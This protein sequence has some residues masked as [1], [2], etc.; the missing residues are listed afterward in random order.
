[1]LFHKHGGTS[2]AVVNCMSHISIF[3]PTKAT[4]KMANGKTGHAEGIGIILCYFHNCPIIFLVGPVCC[5]P[6]HPSN[7]TSRVTSNFML[8]L[9]RLHLN[10][11]NIQI[12][13]NSRLLLE[14]NLPDSKQFILSSN[15]NVHRSTLKETGILWSQL[16]VPYQNRISVSLFISALVMSLLPR[17]NGLKEKYP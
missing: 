15:L 12:L 10:L 13:C 11:L 14:I 2:I 16:H 6:D 8:V 3:F 9:E 5:C 1:M 17:Q 4:V 7:T